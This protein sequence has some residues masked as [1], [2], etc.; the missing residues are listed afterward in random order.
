MVSVI[1]LQQRAVWLPLQLRVCGRQQLA[2]L[3][4]VI[5]FEF[6]P[7]PCTDG[8]VWQLLKPPQQLM[9]TKLLG[10]L[11]C[12]AGRQPFVSVLKFVMG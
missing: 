4:C 11:L 1:S 9:Y 12:L 2:V 5:D 8:L 10:M 3:T 6:S 7:L